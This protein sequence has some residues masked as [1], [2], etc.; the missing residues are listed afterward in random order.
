MEIQFNKVSFDNDWLSSMYQL[1]HRKGYQRQIVIFISTAIL[2]RTFMM[3]MNIEWLQLF[4][5]Y[6]TLSVLGS[7]Q[8]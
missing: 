1:V 2:Y 6:R 8:R 3:T 7:I 4:L 5:R